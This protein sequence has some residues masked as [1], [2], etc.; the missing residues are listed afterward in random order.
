MK[1]FSVVLMLGDY[2]EFKTY[3]N[4]GL[5]YFSL[6][7]Y[8]NALHD[9][10]M[11]LSCGES[12]NYHIQHMIG[13]CLHRLQAYDKALYVLTQAF[14]LNKNFLDALISRGNVLVD[15]GNEFG[16]GRA[17]RDYEYVLL[18][19]PSNVDALINLGYLYQVMGRFKLAW[20]QFSAAIKLKPSKKYNFYGI[21]NH[22]SLKNKIIFV[23]SI[24]KIDLFKYLK[25]SMLHLFI[26]F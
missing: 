1:D 26:Q 8:S 20:E 14:D 7:D 5:L 24:L 4:R 10:E 3:V 15:Y 17:K 6:N 25:K 16:F 22:D 11:A 12:N 18:K 23:L 13:I 19:E 2:L 21:I 9:F